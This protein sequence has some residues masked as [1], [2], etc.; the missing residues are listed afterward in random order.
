M[1]CKSPKAKPVKGGR[2]GGFVSTGTKALEPEAMESVEE[3]KPKGRRSAGAITPYETRLDPAEEAAK[4][5]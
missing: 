2:K 1:P 3:V 5:E 4:D